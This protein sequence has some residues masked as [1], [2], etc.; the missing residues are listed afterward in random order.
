[1]ITETQYMELSARNARHI[2]W[3][4]QFIKKNGWIMITTEEQKTCPAD[5]TM[6]NENRSA[7]ELFEF[8]R[9]K[10]EKYVLYIKEETRQ[11]ITFTG[12]VLGSVAFGQEYHANIG[13]KRMPVTIRAINGAIYHGTYYKSSG[14]YAR[15]RKAKVTK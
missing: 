5:A 4:A 11:A 9:D 7:I 10:P 15:V 3:A 6:T 13:G 14:S 12:D 1:M 8:C 2:A